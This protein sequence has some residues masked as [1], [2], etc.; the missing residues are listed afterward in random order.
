MIKF[1][2]VELPFEKFPNGEIKVN[3]QHIMNLMIGFNHIHFKYENDSD[4]IKLMFVK[5]YLDE[6][7]EKSSLTI[8]YMP[9]S[10][11]DRVEENSVFTLKYV[12]E[13]INS[14][15]F[16]KVFVAEPHSDVTMALLD[17]SKLL[18]VTTNILLQVLIE[19]EFDK[20]NDYLIFPDAGAQKRY[21]KLKGYKQLIGHKNRDWK[22]GEITKLDLV[23][24]IPNK[25]FNAIIID[26]LSSYGT[27]F[28]KTAERLKE[29][30][31]EKIYLIVAH[32][33][34]SIFKGSLFTSSVI[35]KVFTTDSILNDPFNQK[36][37][38]FKNQLKVYNIQE[39][40]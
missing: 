26:D 6:Y 7:D 19:V 9:Y 38:E 14:L 3:G 1:N 35:D 29:I 17:K 10:R 27:T 25:M 15:N 36:F 33:E 31:A 5:K 12:S 22:T 34:D 28:I 37:R 40:I 20:D 16:S 32:A 21:G 13:F 2:G 8:H 18:N 11:M 30:G 4:L 23:G 39:V 24:E